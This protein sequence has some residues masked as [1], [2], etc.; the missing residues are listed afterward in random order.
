MLDAGS[1]SASISKWFP[2]LSSTQIESL[3][4]FYLELI[5]QNKTL[6]LIPLMSVKNAHSVHV[7]D[8]VLAY[9]Y[10]AKNLLPGHPLYIFGSSNGLPGVVFAILN[11]ELKIIIVDRDTKKMEFVKE[12]LT[13]L[14]L[15]NVSLLSKSLE[16]LPAGSVMNACARGFA[17]FSKILLAARKQ[18]AKKGRFF[19][20]KSDGWANELAGLPSQLFS[21]WSPSMIGKYRQPETTTDMFVVQ[22]EKTSD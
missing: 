6:N 5:K 11:P 19:H 4:W 21:H 3:T 13:K 22:T 8:S 9:G 18:M 12:C 14:R 2:N 7:A 17:P 1:F 10:V 20:L 16:E 15:T